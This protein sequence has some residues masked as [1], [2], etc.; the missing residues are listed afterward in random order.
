MLILHCRRLQFTLVFQGTKGSCVSNLNQLELFHCVAPSL[1][2][3]E[4]D[5]CAPRRLYSTSRCFLLKK[6]LWN[7]AGNC[8]FQSLFI[9]CASNRSGRIKRNQQEEFL[10]TDVYLRCVG[11]VSSKGKSKSREQWCLHTETLGSR[12]S[13][14]TLYAFDNAARR[15]TARV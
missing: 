1:S 10:C 8:R 12:C 2:S 6:K 3:E 11:N 15:Q 7:P 13:Q 14:I 9:Q 4:R 5:G